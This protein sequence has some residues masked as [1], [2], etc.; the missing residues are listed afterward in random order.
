MPNPAP[1]EISAFG[2]LIQASASSNRGLE[3]LDKCLFPTLPR[4][5]VSDG[6]DGLR[7]RLEEDGSQFQLRVNDVPVAASEH[8]ASLMPFA[9]QEIDEFV[10][11]KLTGLR[12]IHAGAVQFQGKVLLLPGSS[13]AGKSSMVAELLRR[14]A[15]YLSD[16]Y[17]LIDADGQAHPYPRPLLLR[18]GGNDRTPLL[19][20][21]CG[22]E[23]ASGPAPIGWIMQL[24]YRDGAAWE[25]LPVPQSRALLM[26]LGHTP[27]VL[28]D[29]PDLIEKFQRAVAGARCYA[30]LRT[31][32]SAAADEIL[33]VIASPS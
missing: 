33:R 23:V 20:Q 1:F 2:C 24:E 17:A 18:N 32:A 25:I 8:A 12:A 14:G 5:A 9:I 22:A 11:R 15:A 30:G 26:L 29:A 10:I 16:E 7:I 3:I 21:E 31:D 13:H 4:T 27:H 28:A 19:P 6:A